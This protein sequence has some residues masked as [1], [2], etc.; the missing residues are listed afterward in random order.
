M[1]FPEAFT[2]LDAGSFNLRIQ[3]ARFHRTFE[4]VQGGHQFRHSANLQGGFTLA[5]FNS[6]STV[7]QIQRQLAGLSGTS[8]T[9]TAWHFHTAT[10]AFIISHR[11]KTGH[12]EAGARLVGFGKRIVLHLV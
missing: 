7:A 5:E 3:L 6:A 10:N 4:Q 9:N 11:Q 1:L 12:G 8:R 2:Q